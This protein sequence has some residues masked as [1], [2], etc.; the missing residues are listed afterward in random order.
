MRIKFFSIFA[1]SLLA[2]AVNN[3]QAVS[4]S[5]VPDSGNAV[6]GTPVEVAV[7]IADLGDFSPISLSSFDLD[8][9]FDPLVLGF[10]AVVF[11]DELDLF[12]GSI[13]I[14]DDSVAGVVRLIEISFDLS[15]DLDTFQPGFFTLA[16]LT[17]I[18]VAE[19][20][21]SLGLT[22]NELVDADG[23]IF[24]VDVNRVPEPGSM[25]LLLVGLL[26]VGAGIRGRRAAGESA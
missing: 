1:A 11:G 17:F 19:A 5:L 15:S 9:L 25:M 22:V 16:T 26:G 10:D 13:R 14:E 24:T 4:I 18:P 20:A 8:V 23:N 7:T 3:V 21:F 2:M 12:F 6:I